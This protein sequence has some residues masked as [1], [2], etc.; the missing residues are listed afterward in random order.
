MARKQLELTNHEIMFLSTSVISH[1]SDVKQYASDQRINWSPEARMYF[2]EMI[3]AGTSLIKKFDEMGID[4]SS[5]PDYQPGD[6]N[7]FLTK[8]S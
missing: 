6:L 2:R 5:M 3:A 4:V 1:L 8:E 7:E